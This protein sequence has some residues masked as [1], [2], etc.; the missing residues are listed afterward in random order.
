M[1]GNIANLSALDA[2]LAAN[3][4]DSVL[5]DNSTQY[6]LFAPSNEA[7]AAFSGDITNDQLLYHVVVGTYLSFDV[8]DT[9][10]S[11]PTANGGYANIT[12]INT[13]G[14]VTVTDAAGRVATVTTANIAGTNGVVHI[15]DTVLEYRSIVDIVVERDDLSTLETALGTANLVSAL[16]EDG[17]F[18]VLAPT[19]DAF[20]LIDTSGL[21]TTEL[22]NVL[23]YHVISGAVMSGDLSSGLVAGTLIGESVT[24]QIDSGAYFYDSNGRM[25]MVTVADIVGTNGVIHVID[26]VLL[27]GG[28]IDDI[29]GN[30]ADLSALDDAL[31]ANGLDL[32]LAD[33][34]PAKFTLFAP[35]DAA[36]GAY[37]GDITEE[38]LIYHVLEGQYL[39]DDVATTATALTT[40]NGDEITVI[41]TNGVVTV[42]DSEGNVATVTMANTVGVNGVV[43]VIDSVLSPMTIATT[44]TTMDDADDMTTMVS[45]M[46]TTVDGTMD[47]SNA[48]SMNAIIALS[49]GLFAYL[50]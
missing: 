27:P 44:R 47:G 46:S 23:S 30:I 9:E 21:N 38:L 3:G 18:T 29:T 10:T 17:P 43:H 5:A 15:I 26:A 25:A 32:I 41:N 24:S 16:L 50:F 33:N 12:V 8:P 49:I 42:T 14:V 2:A 36:V 7:I 28:T 31:D 34:N 1:G 39:A 6:T 19:D 22:A 40:V 20:A 37:S 35:T 45:D 48:N 13:N 4:L 11:L